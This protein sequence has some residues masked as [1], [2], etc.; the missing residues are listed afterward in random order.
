MPL[1]PAEKMKRYR[2]KLKLNPE[3]MDIMRQ[4]NLERIKSRYKYKKISEMTEAEKNIQR[5]KW[6]EEKQKRKDKKKSETKEISA[7]SLTKAAAVLMEPAMETTSVASA[8]EKT[9]SSSTN[10]LSTLAKSLRKSRNKLKQELNRAQSRISYLERA[11]E[12]KRK[13]IYRLQKRMTEEREKFASEILKMKARNEILE[14][15]LKLTYKN[16]ETN[17][18]KNIIKSIAR[19]DVVKQN[20]AQTYISG[21][22][23]VRIRNQKIKG[24]AREVS[25]IQKS[26][27]A[28]FIRDDVSRATAGKR[29]CKTF[30]KNKQ[31]IRYLSDSLR[32]LYL[33]YKK[34]G[35]LASF[36]SFC[37]YKPF[38]VLSP[39]IHNRNT[40]LCIKHSNMNFKIA[41]LNRHK[42]IDFNNSRALL[43][44]VSC[45]VENFECMY[46]K[47]NVCNNTQLAYNLD[48]ST[49][50]NITW[51]MWETVNH[52]YKKNSKDGIEVKT[53]KTIKTQKSGTV[54]ELINMFEADIAAFKTHSFNSLHQANCYK[55]C[56]DNLLDG[57]I[58]IHC[59]FSQNYECKMA[60]EVQ[61]MH[62]GAS[63]TQVTLH[64][65][66]IFYKGG[67][68]SF[69]TVSPSNE[70][71][72]HAIW[73]HLKPIID[74]GKSLVTNL[75]KI[76]VF[77]DGPSSQYRQKKNFYLI[78]YFSSLNDIDVTWS[79]FESGHGKGVADAIGG[80]VKRC[81]DRQV[82]YGRDIINAADVY[83]TLESLVKSINV[84]YVTETEIESMKECVPN[85][86]KTIK[87]TMNIHQITSVHGNN[88][89]QHRILSCFCSDNK[90]SCSCYDPIEHTF[91]EVSR[92]SS[93]FRRSSNETMKV[94]IQN[95]VKEKRESVNNDNKLDTP[96]KIRLQLPNNGS[97]IDDNSYHASHIDAANDLPI[98]CI[99]DEDLPQP[100]V[101]RS[102]YDNDFCFLSETKIIENDKENDQAFYHKEPTTHKKLL[103]SG[104]TSNIENIK[105]PVLKDNI[106]ISTTPRKLACSKCNNPSAM[107]NVAK[108]MSCKKFFCFKCTEGQLY[109]DYICDFCFGEL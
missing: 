17:K 66:V 89:I 49:D 26:I 75:K 21:K 39:N 2:E 62:F 33:K 71:Q 5:K 41:A 16:C 9:F 88:T 87:G 59:D 65:G 50:Q 97:K 7:S 102:I 14:A 6:K 4:K 100:L 76:H 54:L 83:S 58:A 107:H 92:M 68:K 24:G 44:K 69:C 43:D 86:L 57:E 85:N 29:E 18:E 53:K 8:I 109:F 77:S 99:N 28:F 70:H 45:N 81:L 91:D 25:K 93:Q 101:N 79:F 36:S 11:N 34:E 80:V 52:L 23:G 46:G 94:N 103:D 78:N 38:Y 20:K 90:L 95:A 108:C 67:Q 32:A 84:V 51:Q 1:T 63:K 19:N 105:K 60:E 104:T 40:C 35:G 64:T 61:S 31:Q 15:S 30:K 47:C 3:K 106:L 72:P 13:N 55:N 98:I 42:I 37:R 22:I 56:I 73:A 82:S 27:L 96:N 74:I 10:T 48:I 12:T